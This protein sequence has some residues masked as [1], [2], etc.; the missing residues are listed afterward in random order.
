MWFTKEDNYWFVRQES[1]CSCT[2]FLS[3]IK[4]AKDVNKIQDSVFSQLS[5]KNRQLLNCDNQNSVPVNRWFPLYS[6]D[7]TRYEYVKIDRLDNYVDTLGDYSVHDYRPYVLDYFRGGVE[8]D[9]LLPT[10]QEFITEGTKWIDQHVNGWKRLLFEDYVENPIEA[11]NFFTKYGLWGEPEDY[12]L[13]LQT[14]WTM[15][16]FSRFQKEH[17]STKTLKDLLCWYVP[18]AGVGNLTSRQM[19]IL[20]ERFAP[21]RVRHLFRHS[22]YELPERLQQMTSK[23]LEKEKVP[24]SV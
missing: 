2:P 4:N 24:F 12:I 13:F 20:D 6:E 3:G 16:N 14:Q 21:V 9:N 10:A 5:E 23:P 7:N 19:K 11:Q 1:S 22:T 15:E 18:V 17:Y 8:E